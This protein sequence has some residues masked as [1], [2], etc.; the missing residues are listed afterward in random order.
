MSD[1]SERVAIVTPVRIAGDVSTGFCRW[2]NFVTWRHRVRWLPIENYSIADGRNRGVLFAQELVPDVEHILFIDSDI[3]PPDDALERL[4]AHDVDIVGG[5]YPQVQDFDERDPAE[6]RLVV[7]AS[8]C[9]KDCEGPYGQLSY[10][11]DLPGTLFECDLL[12]GGCILVK[13]DVFRHLKWP[14]FKMAFDALGMLW[15]EDYAF[16]ELARDGGYKIHCDPTVVCRHWH[17]LDV[18]RMLGAAYT[19]FKLDAESR[20]YQPEDWGDDD[21]ADEC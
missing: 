17:G 21:E 15:P 18:T 13:A 20:K 19:T 7:R 9:Q 12:A 3:E 10:Y 2:L 8:V 1:Y 11:H 16:C 5:I 14:W 6:T 4:M